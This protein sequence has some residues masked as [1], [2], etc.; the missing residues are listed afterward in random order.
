[1]EDNALPAATREWLEAQLGALGRSRAL[2]IRRAAAVERASP[3]G[4]EAGRPEADAATEW[5]AAAAV[6]A[7]PGAAAEP[8]GQ[9]PAG[10]TRCYLAVAT[11]ARRDLYRF[12]VGAPADLAAL[13][14]AGGLAAG[15]LERHRSAERLTL[16]CTNG[17][18]D[19]CCAR[20]GVPVYHALRAASGGDGVW[21][22]TH[23]GGHRHAASALWLPEGVSWG[24][25]EPGDAVRLAAARDHGAILLSRYRGRT[26]HPAP[27][28]AADAALRAV[29]GVEALDAWAAVE[30]E[31][32]GGGR[33]AVRFATA[34]EPRRRFTAIV[35]GEREAALVSCS[36]PKQKAVDA[37]R[38]V[39]WHEED[40]R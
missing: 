4:R 7:D 27:A 37:Y 22:S 20:F 11:A 35:D 29:L 8:G 38:L 33:W 9:G 16:V 17:R 32:L 5:G 10:A 24:Y 14:L 21:Q 6:P 12:D 18:R 1:V 23:Q 26:F 3:E 2:L 19:R 39:D 28:Q 34:A 30:P 36:P 15:R 25:L 31:E 40:P 13:D